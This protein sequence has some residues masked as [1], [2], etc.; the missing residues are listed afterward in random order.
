MK[1][2]R[3]MQSTFTFRTFL[4]ILI[5]I[6]SVSAVSLIRRQLSANQQLAHVARTVSAQVM[7][8]ASQTRSLL[9]P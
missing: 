2:T 6:G 7:H 5:F 3:V 9:L 1:T 4:W 8:T